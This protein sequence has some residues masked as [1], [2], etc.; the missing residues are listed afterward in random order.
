MST[1]L[2]TVN[3]NPGTPKT[4]VVENAADIYAARKHVLEII[5]YDPGVPVEIT[6][7]PI[8]TNKP[9]R[10]SNLGRVAD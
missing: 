7:A 6:E 1:F 2:V 8:N 9:H 3:Y 10:F 4:Y 5:G